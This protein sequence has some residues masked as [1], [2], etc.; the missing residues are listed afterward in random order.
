MWTFP[1]HV[2]DE[3]TVYILWQHFKNYFPTAAV[4]YCIYIFRN[5]TILYTDNDVTIFVNTIMNG[6]Y[7]FLNIKCRFININSIVLA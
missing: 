1:G 4:F 6:N 3:L 7:I 2:L 5:Y